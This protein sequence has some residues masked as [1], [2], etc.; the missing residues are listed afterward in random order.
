MTSSPLRLG[1]IMTGWV[2]CAS[3]LFAQ[4]PSPSPAKPTVVTS[5]TF[6]MDM[7]QNEGVFTGNVVVTGTD[8]RMTTRELRVYFQSD[9]KIERMLARGD[10]V[11]T[12]PNRTTKSGQA[13]YFTEEGKVV[14]TDS[15]EV[16]D[17]GK[18]I[19]GKLIR[20]FRAGNRMEVEERSRVIIPPGQGVEPSGGLP[21]SAPAPR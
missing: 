6:K 5:E 19:T 16:N 9:N 1:L 7:G 11:I 15:P 14:L 8:F 4:S 13:E 3:A 17:N 10:V 21:G 12:Q 2:W 18:I 20:F